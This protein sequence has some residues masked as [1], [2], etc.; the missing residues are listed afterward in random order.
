MSAPN[1]EMESLKTKLKAM[2]MSGDFGQIA[3]QLETSAEE[4]INR[5]GLKPG[6][7][8]LDV[9]CGSG[10]TA[11]PAARAGAIVTGADIATNLLEQ[12]RH[13]PLRGLTIQFDE[14]D[15][16]DLPYTDASFD[17]VVSMFGAMFAPRPNWWLLNW[18]AYAVL[19]AGSRWRIGHRKD[20]LARC[21]K[22]P[23]N[24]CRHHPICRRQSNGETR[25][26]CA[27]VFAREFPS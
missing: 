3:K 11:I 19:A 17:V 23:A 18:C 21:S 8:V 27:N 13:A 12:G 5:L 22:P 14:G 4:F 20:T 6:E 25:P 2:W 24:M 1:T 15:A 7:R 9:A 26:L 10:N 16:E